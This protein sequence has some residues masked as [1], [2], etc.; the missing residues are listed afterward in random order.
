MSFFV[1]VFQEVQPEMLDRILATMRGDFAQSHRTHPGR[2]SSRIFQGLGR[3]ELLIA[4]AEWDSRAAYDRLWQSPTYQELTVQADPPATIEVLTRLRSFT[5][6]SALPAYVACI[7]FTASPG[8]ADALER[9]ILSDIR[10]D[11]EASEGL[12]SHDVFRVGERA[13]QLLIVHGWASLEGL[14]QFR[15]RTRPHHRALLHGLHSSV[16]RFTGTVAAQYARQA[17]L[18]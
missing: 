12:V 7:R 2:R 11:V 1:A 16:E 10:R 8:Q 5:R 18:H 9:M 15:A 6:M 13:G 14:E 17:Q 3:P 4:V